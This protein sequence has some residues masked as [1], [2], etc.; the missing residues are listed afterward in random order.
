MTIALAIGVQRMARRG[1]IVRR[2]PAVETLGSTTV[3]CT[4]KT[5]TLTRNEMTV[6]TVH[7]PGAREIEVTGAGYAPE[8]QFF[9]GK[10]PIDPEED[11]ALLELLRAGVLCNDANL[12]SPELPEAPWRVMGDPT[13]AALLA[14][15]VKGNVAPASL[16]ESY[17]RRAEL[18]FDPTF[19]MMATQHDL[20]GDRRVF[21]KG[22]PEAVLGLCTSVRQDG[23]SEPLGEAGREEAR[24]AAKRM[25][26]RALRVLAF[27]VIDGMAIDG[28]AG[29]LAFRGKA[30]FL[31]LVG[32]LDP[33]RPEVGIAIRESQE[34][35]IRVVMVTGDHKE[36]GLAIAREL[37]IAREGDLGVDGRELERMSEREL[38]QRIGGISVFARVHPAQKLRIVDAY[39]KGGR[40]GGD[41]WRRCER[42][43]GAR[44]G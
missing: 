23:R 20:P 26:S 4:D 24:G 44:Q 17:P 16:R 43:A 40:G 7:L 2:L 19:Q 8:G 37:G 42:R 1:A 29:F 27:A 5:G 15:A 39:Q 11:E 3:I 32:Q 18:S 10:Q 9:E 30:T 38:A 14:L 12:I 34:A 25:A 6:T 28:R 33:P 36:T 21:V 31:G 35:G 41:D 22:A 13:E